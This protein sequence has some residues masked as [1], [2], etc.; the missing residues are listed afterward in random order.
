MLNQRDISD[1]SKKAQEVYI[2]LIEDGHRA[3]KTGACHAVHRDKRPAIQPPT[4]EV[5]CD[6]EDPPTDQKARF[7]I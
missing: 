3:A 7:H 6:A 4:S 1:K 2:L 5:R